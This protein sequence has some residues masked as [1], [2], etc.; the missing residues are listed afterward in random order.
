MFVARSLGL[1][2]QRLQIGRARPQLLHQ[3]WPKGLVRSPQLR[4]GELQQARFSLHA[5]RT[6]LEY[7]RAIPR[8][9]LVGHTGRCDVGAGGTTLDGSVVSAT[10]DSMMR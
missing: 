5:L 1:G 2:A 8:A 10:R 4:H 7:A 3:L 9:T 6:S